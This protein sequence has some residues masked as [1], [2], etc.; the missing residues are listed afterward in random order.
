[1]IIYY[2]H[3][4]YYYYCCYY[5]YYYYYY[6][7]MFSF[8]LVLNF[9]L[10]FW[11]LSITVAARSKALTVFVHLNAGLVGSNFTRDRDVSVCLFSAFIALIVGSGLAM[12]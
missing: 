12:G 4:I 5:Y 1:M 9:S 8:T 2:I 11:K 6:Y 7:Y 3:N 10:Q